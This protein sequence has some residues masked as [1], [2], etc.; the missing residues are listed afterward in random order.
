MLVPL[1]GGLAVIVVLVVYQYRAAA[2]AHGPHHA[3]QLDPGRRDR[4]RAVRGRGVGLGAALTAKRWQTLQPGHIGLLYLPELGGAVI[5]A[6]VLGSSSRGGR[7]N[8][9]RWPA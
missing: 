9:C 5:T 6:V 3:D 2:A 7:S 8:T 4:R 1:L